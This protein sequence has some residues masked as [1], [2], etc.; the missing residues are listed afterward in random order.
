MLPDKQN[1]NRIQFARLRV[2][3]PLFMSLVLV[4]AVIELTG[5]VGTNST[6]NSTKPGTFVSVTGNW[7]LDATPSS[8]TPPFTVLSGFFNELGTNPASGDYVSAALQVQSTT[9]YG[10]STSVPVQGLV[11]GN[12]LTL[13]S[14]PVDGQEIAITATK[15]AAGTQM[16]GDYNIIGGCA[17]GDEGTLVG[18]LYA[19]VN[20]TYSGTVQMASSPETIQLTLAQSTQGTGT[21]ESLVS[22]SAVFQGFSCFTSGTLQNTNSYVIGS[23][24]SLTFTTNEMSGSQ[25]TMA[26]KIDPAADTVTLSSINVTGGS[27]SGSIGAATLTLNQ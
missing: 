24:A 23:T 22:G 10:A 14:F 1:M 13:A 21:G 25:I 2:L 26:G 20:G 4:L 19:P 15:N 27:C 11:A 6:T 17:N 8:G 9:C 7:E 12:V 16:T 18:T 5:C 3:T